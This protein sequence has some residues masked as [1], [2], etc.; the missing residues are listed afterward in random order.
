MNAIIYMRNTTGTERGFIIQNAQCKRFAT[1]HGYTIVGEYKEL[2]EP[3]PER[4]LEIAKQGG[5]KFIIVRC[6]YNIIRYGSRIF[7][8]FCRQLTE[9]G[10]QIISLNDRHWMPEMTKRF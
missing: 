9:C 3:N 6:I 1:R 5:F 10:V 8:D 7:P 4:I 2:G